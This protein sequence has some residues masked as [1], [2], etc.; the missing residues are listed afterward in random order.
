MV[1]RLPQNLELHSRYK[2]SNYVAGE[3]L[4]TWGGFDIIAPNRDALFLRFYRCETRET[5]LVGSYTTL[6]FLNIDE[7]HSFP[8]LPSWI[9]QPLALKRRTLRKCVPCWVAAHSVRVEERF[10]A[11][12]GAARL[13]SHHVRS[14]LELT[15]MS[16]R[17]G[18][19]F[20]RAPQDTLTINPSLRDN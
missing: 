9:L 16:R 18:I 13:F 4:T 17:V 1:K 7:K 3:K 8:L 6:A 2:R 12:E 11:L 5:L 20:R 14:A 15:A 10:H 19:L